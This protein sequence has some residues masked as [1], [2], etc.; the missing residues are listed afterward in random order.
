MNVEG[1]TEMTKSKLRTVKDVSDEAWDEAW[2]VATQEGCKH[3]EAVNKMLLEYG[4]L[5]ACTD[6]NMSNKAFM[7]REEEIREEANKHHKYTMMQ[8]M[9]QGNPS[10]AAPPDDCVENKKLLFSPKNIQPIRYYSKECV[11]LTFS[12][13]NDIDVHNQIVIWLR[14]ESGMKPLPENKPWWKFWG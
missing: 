1:K 4:Y 14:E 6:A 9:M 10:N 12:G 11:N 5:K 2:K 13:V 3:G 8:A 7:A